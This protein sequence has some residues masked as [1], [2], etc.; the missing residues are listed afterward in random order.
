MNKENFISSRN[1]IL[2]NHK[3][4][5]REWNK[6]VAKLVR[7]FPIYT[8][9]ERERYECVADALEKMDEPLRS[10]IILTVEEPYALCSLTKIKGSLR[11]FGASFLPNDIWF[12]D[13]WLEFP[14]FPYFVTE[15]ATFKSLKENN[16]VLFADPCGEIEDEP[17]IAGAEINLETYRRR[18]IVS[19]EIELPQIKQQGCLLLNFSAKGYYGAKVKIFNN[20][21]LVC[22]SFSVQSTPGDRTPNFWIFPEW[23]SG[24]NVIDLKFIGKGYLWFDH[25]DIHH[26]FY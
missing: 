22:P 2:T 14:K 3:L 8:G 26:V 19:I 11:I 1:T 21:E 20:G 16:L 6:A 23:K 4:E 5:T 9:R 18:P 15:P 12:M 25:V 24:L 17:D 10:D 13:E 7:E